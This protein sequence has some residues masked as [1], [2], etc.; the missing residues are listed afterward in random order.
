GYPPPTGDVPPPGGYPPPGGFDPKGAGYPAGGAYGAPPPGYPSA[1][2]KTWALVAHFGGAAGMFLGG[3][4]LG[5]LAPL[6]AL[7]ARGNQSP[8]ARAHA[9]AALNF[10]ILWSIIAVV[11][12]ILS[13]I[14]IGIFIGFAATIIGIIFGVVA[15]LKANEG[16]LYRYPMSATF[17]K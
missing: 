16:Q 11:G 15:G 1:E 2:D 6:I 14:I 7:L 3:G 12:W 17:I 9:V 5:W 8:A 4:T 13:C 10:Q